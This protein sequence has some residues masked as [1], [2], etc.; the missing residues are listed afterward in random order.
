[1]KKLFFIYISL[2]PLCLMAQET[3]FW[4]DADRYLIR[5]GSHF[6][7]Q[8]DQA[9][10]EFKP[11]TNNSLMRRQALYNMD[12]ILH[13][14]FYDKS[15]EL[16]TFMTSRIGK[17]LTDLDTQMVEGMKIYKLYN[18]GFIAKAGGVTVAFDIISGGGLIS[19]DLLE[20]IVD[21]CDM[22]CITHKHPDHAEDKVANL[23]LSKG[24]PVYAPT[25]ALPEIKGITHIYK[26]NGGEMTTTQ[27]NLKDAPVIMNILHGHQDELQN[28]IY[29]VTLPGNYTVCQTGDQY[30]EEDMQWIQSAYSR[31]PKI[32]ALLVICWSM[33]LQEF[34]NGF[35]PQI[36]IS[37]HEN[38]IL[39][40]G[41]DHREAYWLSYEK[42]DTIRQPYCLMTWGEWITIQH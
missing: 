33:H 25:E 40:H 5:Q 8:I 41:I 9:L 36:V 4:G 14:T 10:D 21:R 29:V 35:Q 17:V 26:G 27:V 24:K 31:L 38:E 12:A 11:D 15:D 22:M 34:V 20:Q 39:Y 1:M 16:K 28:N 32:D 6:L 18:D 37:G 13:N 7:Q 42:F 23:F 19:D 3:Q 2:L 30:L